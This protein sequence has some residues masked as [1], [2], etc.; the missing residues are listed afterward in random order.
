MMA[1]NFSWGINNYLFIRSDLALVLVVGTPYHGL[2]AE[3][4]VSWL[5]ISS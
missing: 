5:E 4:W 1:G 2:K 3:F